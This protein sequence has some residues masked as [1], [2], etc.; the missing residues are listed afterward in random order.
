MTQFQV[1]L[2]QNFANRLLPNGWWNTCFYHYP[3]FH[4]NVSHLFSAS[5]KGFLIITYFILAH[6]TFI[7]NFSCKLKLKSLFQ[8]TFD[9]DSIPLKMTQFQVSLSQNFANRLL[10]NGWWNTCF[11]HYPSFHKNV[12]HLFS[13][14]AKGFLIITYFILAH[15]TFITN[16]SCKLK[17]KS[18]FQLTFDEDS[19]PLKMSPDHD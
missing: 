18:L 11:Y 19:I 7:T 14:S 2:S 17:L 15:S 3:C 1:S 8:L 9:E 16:F 6:S 5:A 4:R 13:A 10:P 12:S